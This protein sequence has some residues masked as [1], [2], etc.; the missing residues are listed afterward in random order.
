MKNMAGYKIMSRFIKKMFIGLL[1]ICT[2]RSFGGF[3][4]SNSKGPITCLSLNNRLLQA[5]PTLVSINFNQL[6]Y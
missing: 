5:R 4:A 2:A 3:L 1:S 6:L